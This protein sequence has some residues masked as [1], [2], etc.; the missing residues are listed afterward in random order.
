[1][2]Y[3]VSVLREFPLQKLLSVSLCCRSG[4]RSCSSKGIDVLGYDLAEFYFDT[5]REALNFLELQCSDEEYGMIADSKCYY[6]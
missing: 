6:D 5:F 2:Y 3:C 1:M 4:E